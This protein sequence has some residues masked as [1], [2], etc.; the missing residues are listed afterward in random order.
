MKSKTLAADYV[1]VGAGSAG[2]VLAGRLSEDENCSV[3]LIEAGGTDQRLIVK[4]PS[5]FYLPMQRKSLNWRYRSEPE[6]HMHNRQLDC[7]RGRGLGGSSSINGMVYA[8]GN[9]G[10]FERWAGLG[11]EGWGYED[12]L[13][14]FKKAQGSRS[15][16]RSEVAR[17]FDGPLTTTDGVMTNPLY[18][19][20]IEAAQQAGYPYTA[21]LNG[22]Q[23]EGFGPMPMTVAQGQRSSTSR[24]YLRPVM[25]RKNLR[26]LTRAQVQRIQLHDKK[27]VAVDVLLGGKA[28]RLR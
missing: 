5:A 18:A 19:H 8:R 14:Y 23:Q 22:A 26:V 16:S 12:V 9:A 4:M 10:D 3:I 1:V 7:P 17:G 25:Q 27:A 2:C 28:Q 20:F 6:P 21:D 13:P 15:G 24:S 11:A